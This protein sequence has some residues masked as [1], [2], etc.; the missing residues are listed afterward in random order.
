[1]C[2]VKKEIKRL[3]KTIQLLFTK[4]LKSLY[5]RIISDFPL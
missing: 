4:I 2:T 3:K 5:F 1:M